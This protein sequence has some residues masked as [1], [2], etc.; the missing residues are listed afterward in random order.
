TQN[1]LTITR[2]MQFLNGAGT[3]QQHPD[4]NT[5]SMNAN[6]TVTGTVT[7]TSQVAGGPNGTTSVNRVSSET[8]TGLGPASTQRV[9]NGTAT[10]AED[11]DGS[12]WR[13]TLSIKRTYADTTK[14]MTLASPPNQA[15]P[16]PVS[17]TII[18]NVKAKVAVNG[19]AEK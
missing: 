18:R 5:R 1:G 13:G 7:I 10:G 16:F 19:G 3:P 12:D 9:V 15:A 11:S 17:G 2:Q 6:T 4:S 8:V 14:D